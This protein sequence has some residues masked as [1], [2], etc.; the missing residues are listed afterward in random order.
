M[1]SSLLNPV[2]DSTP[3]VLSQSGAA[4]ALTGT[5]NEI[6]LASISI[7]AGAL[8]KHGRLRFWGALSATNNANAKTLKVKLNGN[9]IGGAL[10][11]ASTGTQNFEADMVNGHA[12]N[13]NYGT[14]VGALGATISQA[15]GALSIDTTQAMTLTVTGQLATSTDTLTLQAYSLEIF[16]V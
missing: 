8:R 16:N 15:G 5:V 2:L 12:P 1:T 6:V 4:V 7:P 3:G 14:I 13:A 9:I 10:A 11:L